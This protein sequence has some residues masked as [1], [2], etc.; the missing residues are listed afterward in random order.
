MKNT[1]KGLAFLLLLFMFAC[2]QTAQSGQE[3]TADQTEES[4]QKEADTETDE[5]TEDDK[6]NRPSPPKETSGQI[7][8]ADIKINYSSPAVKGRTIWGGLE[9]Y[10]EVW[11]TGANEATTI[12]FSKDVTIEGKA[13]AAGKYALF[14]IPNEDKWVIIFNNEPDQW[15][16]Y[17]YDESKD[18]LR[19][20]VTPKNLEEQVERMEFVVEGDIVA[21]RWDKL[22]VG[23]KVGAAG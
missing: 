6:S 11:R 12:E 4:N 7:A 5:T 18:A 21:L 1:I 16:D 9:P 8:G 23:F 10:G 2:G 14:S 3:E 22:E 19:V 13:L 15:G 20:E 17:N